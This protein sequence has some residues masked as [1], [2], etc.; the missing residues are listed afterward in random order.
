VNK[1]IYTLYIDLLD[2]DH[3]YDY[4]VYSLRTHVKPSRTRVKLLRTRP[5]Y[6]F[7][8]DPKL[9]SRTTREQV[10]SE[11]S[12]WPFYSRMVLIVLLLCSC[13]YRSPHQS[14]NDLF[15]IVFMN[16]KA[17]SSDSS[18][19]RARRRRRRRRRLRRRIQGLVRW[20]L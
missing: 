13:L 9:M 11:Q 8:D 4:L 14:R 2:I 18:S 15:V 19:K 16:N 7:Q 20:S 10:L 6:N 5:I 3:L 1:F 17:L 12:A